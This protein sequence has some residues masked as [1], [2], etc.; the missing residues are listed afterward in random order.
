VIYCQS[1]SN[2][3]AQTNQLRGSLVMEAIF[4]NKE[5]FRYQ[6]QDYWEGCL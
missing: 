3:K 6:K 4:L 5:M 2:E 1:N